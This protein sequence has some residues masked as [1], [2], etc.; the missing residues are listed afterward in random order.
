M[1]QVYHNKQSSASLPLALAKAALPMISWHERFVHP[2]ATT[3][4]ALSSL[5]AAVELLDD[6]NTFCMGKQLFVPS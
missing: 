4:A 6:T 5:T 3:A 2:T 1:I